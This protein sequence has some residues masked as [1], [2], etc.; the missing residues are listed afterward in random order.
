MPSRASS[1]TVRYSTSPALG[2][3]ANSAS[4]CRSKT[5]NGMA[6]R[7][8][9]RATTN[10]AGPAPTIATP[11]L[12]DIG[13]A[14]CQ[15]ER[16]LDRGGE[17]PRAVRGVARGS[18]GHMPVRAYQD[19]AGGLHLPQGRPF[20]I[21]V[22]HAF[23]A[24]DGIDADGYPCAYGD[25]GRRGAPR[26][27]AYAGEQRE[28]QV[29]DEVERGDRDAVAFEPGVRD[30]GAGAGGRLVV[31]LGIACRGGVWAAV[32]G[33]DVASIAVPEFDAMGVELVVAQLDRL[34][35]RVP[36]LVA[37]W[38]GF[39]QGVE[40]FPAGF[41]GLGRLVPE[42][43]LDR[44][45]F[46]EAGNGAL[47][48]LRPDGLS[49]G[50]VAVQQRGARPAGQHEGELPAEVVR[51]RDGHV[52][53]E[54][55]GRR[56]PVDRVAHAEHASGRIA[57][58]DLRPDLPACDTEDLGVD[59]LAVLAVLAVFA[60]EGADPPV[61]LVGAQRVQRYLGRVVHEGQ[62]EL[63]E[64][65]VADHRAEPQRGQRTRHHVPGQDAG[66]VRQ[67]P[68]QVG[69]E[70]DVR[71]PGQVVGSFRRQASLAKDPAAGAVRAY[72]VLRSHGQRRLPVTLLDDAG[73][74]ALVWGEADELP[75]EPDV[76][77]S[78]PGGAQQHWFQH[79]LRAVRHRLGTGHPVVGGPLG[80][81]PP[82]F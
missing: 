54:A 68:G 6:S 4:A 30:A 47:D 42:G 73:N 66:A 64:R 74:A 1:C 69:T 11:G 21:G 19:A 77:A 5:T 51:I 20:A 9:R 55:V 80:A 62:H 18:P 61:Q 24:A 7:C 78:V 35:Q 36:A 50:G 49:F 39:I 17:L 67:V 31:Q 44:G 2:R 25:F 28:A 46:L 10:P 3:R 70:P 81:G 71:G 26:L 60:D 48:A 40:G 8:N 32:V 79:G 43:G 16:L 72:H 41:G 12:L 82:R 22:G 75:P 33:D 13:S 14:A 23:A 56:G 63:G 37:G 45:S 29:V 59:V 76:G 27:T 53:P 15:S 57:G 58:R 34:V 52:E 65:L 38:P